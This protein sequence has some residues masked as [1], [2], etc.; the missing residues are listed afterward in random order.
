MKRRPTSNAPS[1]LSP[2]SLQVAVKRVSMLLD[3]PQEYTRT[4]LDTFGKMGIHSCHVLYV[5]LA[6]TRDNKEVAEAFKKRFKETCQDIV[7]CREQ[8]SSY[9]C[10]SMYMDGR[11]EYDHEYS[12]RMIEQEQRV[13]NK[14]VREIITNL[15]EVI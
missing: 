4:V 11:W 14:A 3:K 12:Q 13:N 2:E 9:R 6:D 5:V 15:G 8:L 10:A 1:N 7:M